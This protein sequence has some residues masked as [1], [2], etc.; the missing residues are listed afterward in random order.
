MA[1]YIK[2]ND[3][4]PAIETILESDDGS[5]IIDL[6]G[7]DVAFHMTHSQRDVEITGA[8]AILD[9]EGGRVRYQW[10]AGDTSVSGWYR[11]EFQVTY[12]DAKIETFPND[13]SIWIHVDGELA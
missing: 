9:E 1:F 13:G 3:T 11:A 6:T 8:C 7:C 2:Q 5:V 10:L 12:S 4:S